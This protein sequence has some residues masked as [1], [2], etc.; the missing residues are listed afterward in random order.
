MSAHKVEGV[1]EVLR[2]EILSGG[3]APGETLPTYDTLVERFKVSRPTVARVVR[4]LRREGLVELNGSRRIVVASRFPH[5]TRY[6]WIAS[7]EP[8]SAHWTRLAA[9]ILYLIERRETGID[10]EVFPLVGVDGRANNPEYQRLCEAVRHRSVAGLFLMTSATLSLLPALQTAGLS[11]VAIQAVLPHAGLTRLDLDALLD[12]ALPRLRERGRRVAVIS[13]HADELERATM[14]L[15]KEGVRK[16]CVRALHVSAVG[17]K[18]MTELLFDRADRPDAVFVTD[19][20]LLRPFLQGL[21]RSARKAG[22]DVYVLAHCN[23]PRPVGWGEGVEHIG[24]DVREVL[25]A[26]KECIDAQTAGETAPVRIIPPRFANEL[27]RPLSL[28]AP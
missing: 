8:R 27:T 24:F 4:E 23:W 25:V 18:Q 20:N 22:R 12:R 13:P 6:L 16:S 14:A 17:C 26:A 5:H 7:E 3:R 21:E 9:T 11:R 19:D 10:G 15:A 2:G 1:V 28:L